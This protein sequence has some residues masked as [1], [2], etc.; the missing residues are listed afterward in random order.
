MVQMNDNKP[1]VLYVI[2]DSLA[3]QGELLAKAGRQ[4]FG[5]MIEDIRVFSFV[6]ERG[7][8]LRIIEEAAGCHALIICTVSLPNILKDLKRFSKERGIPVYDALD[9]F[10]DEIRIQTGTAPNTDPMV[11]NPLD[12]AYFKRV[13]AIEFTV[14]Y[15]D[16]KRMDH[17]DKADIV[18]LGVSRTSKT[19]ISVYLANNNYKVANIPI[20]PEVDPPAELFRL[21]R[22]KVFGLVLNPDKLVEIREE[23]LRTMRLYG[24]SNYASLKRV[25]YELEK[26]QELFD[27]LGCTVIDVTSKAIEEIANFILETILRR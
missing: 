25:E 13:E 11:R 2:S 21:P 8:L 1:L 7:E 15:D 24:T 20:M 23:R 18:L 16:G 17:L 4:H 12:E 5:A 6:R 9:P 22:E 19:P 14:K 10:L 27:R 26:A 3:Q